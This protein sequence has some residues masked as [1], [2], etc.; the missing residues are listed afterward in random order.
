VGS[1]PFDIQ[2]VP[3]QGLLY[4][5]LSEDHE[6][7]ALSDLAA[8]LSTAPELN[9]AA[10]SQYSGLIEQ[11]INF[12]REKIRFLHHSLPFKMVPGIMVVHMVLHNIK[13][14]NEFL[15]R[16]GG[17]ALLPQCNNDWL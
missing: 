16:G 5:R 17:E 3:P 12:L 9:W 2:D 1:S 4:S 6:F 8:N 10:A 13:F 14:V 7:A 15:L 11:N